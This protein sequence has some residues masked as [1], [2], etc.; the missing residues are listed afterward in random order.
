MIKLSNR[1][2]QVTVFNLVT[3][4]SST[5]MLAIS[6]KKTCRIFMSSFNRA[7]TGNACLL[8]SEQLYVFSA[9]GIYVASAEVTFFKV[10]EA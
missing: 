1:T 3:S 4:F 2:V 5:D 10:A 6:I 9:G 7:F 8:Y